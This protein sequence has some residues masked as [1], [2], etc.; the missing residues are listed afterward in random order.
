MPKPDGQT[1]RDA[2]KLTLT[3]GATALVPSQ[4]AFAQAPKADSADDQ[5]AEVTVTGSRIRRVDSETA[6]PVFVIDSDAIAKSGLKTIG[7]IVQR[8]PAISGAAANPQV[9]NGGG[10]GESNIELRGLDAKRTLI[11]LN[12]RRIALIGS[13]AASSGAVDVNQIPVSIIERVEVLKEGAGAIYGSDAIAGVVNFITRQDITSPEISLDYGKTS[14]SD[15]KHYSASLSWGTKSEDS[16]F[17][18]NGSYTKQ[19]QVSANNR[20]FS[21]FALYLYS[22]SIQKG[23]SSRIP[24]GRVFLPAGN[25]LRTSLGCSSATRIAGTSGAATANYRC[26]RNPADLYNYQPFNLLMTPQERGAVFIAGD[27]NLN[28]QVNLYSEILFNRTSSGYQIA[29]LPFDALADDVVVSSQSLYNPFGIDF[30]G[31]NTSRPNFRVRL[32]SLGN[33]FSQTTSDSKILTLGARG[34]FPN[35][36]W[37]WDANVGYSRLDQDQQINGYLYQPGLRSALGPSFLSAGVP[38]CG[39]PAAPIAGCVP[40]NIFNVQ[41]QSSI[42]ALKRVQTG[43]STSHSSIAKGATLNLNGSLLDLPAG[44]L[45]VALGAEYRKTEFRFNVDSIVEAFPPL[46]TNCIIASEACTGDAAAKYDVKELYGELFAPLLKEKPGVYALNASLGVRFSDYSLFGN[47][48][49]A[50]LKLEYRPVADLLIRGTFS[51]VFR[52]PTLGDIGAAPAI[53]NPTF[54]DACFGLTQARVTA[55][56]NLALACQNVARDGSFA[57]DGTSQITGVVTSNPALKPEKGDVTTFGIVFEPSFLRG[58]S[59][60]VDAWRYKIDNLITNVDVNYSLGQCI[61]TGSPQFCGLISRYAAG[62]NQGR[63]ARFLQPTVNLGSLTTKG[64]DIGVKY[65]MRATPVGDFQFSVDSTYNQNYTVTTPGAP[66]EE[67]S[68][69]FSRQ[70]GNYAKWRALAAVGWKYDSFNG[71]LSARYIHKL[72]LLN[73]DGANPFNSASLPIASQ[74]Y[75][76]L[77]LGWEAPSKTKIQIGIDNLT[78][79]QPPLLYQNNVINANTDVSTYDTLGRRYFLSVSQKF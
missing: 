3:A 58:L 15:G 55:N 33:R 76:A 28:E 50:Q 10:F 48:T 65:A 47:S 18:I 59:L 14:Q 2:V 13:P 12:G 17:V 51:Q 62:T 7:D 68:G 41:L 54:A 19:E 75:L 42:D 16:N 77:S 63:I 25:P 32:E 40:I 26:F 61:A 5:L 73:A 37:K 57:S 39:T 4:H 74:T 79:R 45:Q 46:F 30:G 69:T 31:F 11:L 43:Y 36:R 70:F 27:K 8:M 66:S 38:T 44:A 56:P 23:G 72:V 67:I 49:K 52:V 9:N 24:T 60:T 1:I 78:D 29:P 21:R 20:D 35:T 53:S 64:V 22:G 34:E 6:S 71:L